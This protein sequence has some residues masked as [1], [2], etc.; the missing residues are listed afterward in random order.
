MGKLIEVK[1]LTDYSL[2][3]INCIEASAGTGKTYA[4][5]HLYLRLLIQKDYSIDN[6]L[7]VTFTNAATEELRKRI[8]LLIK[9]ARDMI[10]GQCNDEI[11][12]KYAELNQY[13]HTITQEGL[14]DGYK[15]EAS[16]LIEKLQFALREIDK[17]HIYT[18]HSFCRKTLNEFAFESRSL[19]GSTLVEDVRSYNQRIVEDFY[20]EKIVPLGEQFLTLFVQEKE[21]FVE[22]FLNLLSKIPDNPDIAFIP[23]IRINQKDILKTTQSLN[24]LIQH[25]KKL[26]T[27]QKEQIQNNYI[28]AIA[29]GVLNKRSFKEEDFTVLKELVSNLSLDTVMHSTIYKWLQKFSLTN[30][31]SKMNKKANPSYT[32]NEIFTYIDTCIIYIRSIKQQLLGLYREFV[33]YSEQRYASYRNEWNI[34]SFKDI[35]KDM[36]AALHGDSNSPL[37]QRVRGRFKAALIDEFQD[38]DPLQYS[39]FTTIFNFNKEEDTIYVIGDPK[40]AIYK[41]RGA[42]IFAYLNARNSAHTQYVL[43]KSYRSTN[44]LTN[45]CNTIFS[46]LKYPFIHD[47]I[48]YHQVKSDISDSGF[49]KDGAFHIWLFMNENGKPIRIPIVQKMIA[50]KIAQEILRLVNGGYTI[51]EEPIRFSDIA[52]LVRKNFEATLVQKILRKYNIKSVIHSNELVFQTQEAWE[53]LHILE[54]VINPAVTSVIK[55]ALITSILGYSALDIVKLEHSGGID[56]IKMKFAEYRQLWQRKGIVVMLTALFIDEAIVKNNSGATVTVNERICSFPDGERV[57]TNIMHCAEILSKVERTNKLDP[58]A[59]VE[60]LKKANSGYVTI[61]DQELRLE[62]D[63]NAVKIVTV[64][65]SKGLEYPIVFCPYLFDEMRLDDVFLV[66]KNVVNKMKDDNYRA[67]LCFKLSQDQQEVKN[68]IAEKADIPYE[69]LELEGKKEELAEMLR[70]A[71]VAMTRAKYRCYVAWGNINQRHTSALGYLFHFNEDT[72]ITHFIKNFKLDNYTIIHDINKLQKACESIKVEPVYGVDIVPGNIPAETPAQPQ[73]VKQLQHPLHQGWQITSY[74]SLTYRR[75]EEKSDEIHMPVLDR[76]TKA[77][78]SPFTFPAGAVPGLCIHKIF[79]TVPFDADRHILSDMVHSILLNYAIGAHWKDIVTAMVHNVLMVPLKEGFIPLSKVKADQRRHEL[80]FY[81]PVKDI[82]SKKLVSVFGQHNL[83]TGEYSQAMKQLAFSD[84]NG[85]M[86]GYID[87]VFQYDGLFYIIDW[88]SNLLGF[89]IDAYHRSKLSSAII[90]HYY[91]LQYTIYTVALHR[92][93]SHLF[94]KSYS[95]EKNFGGVFYIFVR[96]VDATKG[97]EYGIFYDKPDAVLIEKINDFF[98]PVRA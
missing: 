97:H 15:A 7:V 87:M 53:L 77:D 20:F 33:I 91:F 19:F 8:R 27:D 67:Y 31:V 50:K 21:N 12:N 48:D 75:E 57:I 43:T 92:Y 29:E 24:E 89:S 64:H 79:E 62:S 58:V 95:Y 81:F 70:V 73:L 14:P 60:W 68:Y 45:A 80:E 63:A 40:Q 69:E 26:F 51:N 59:V 11:Q 86:H 82:D 65:S 94:G 55:R 3:G 9:I 90:S 30:I 28:I 76:D 93:L 6:I 35:L 88:K 54:A 38:T 18:I 17:A 25:I 36:H 47:K 39:I 49:D 34:V 98:N 96:G 42:D 66:H 1:K 46:R 83:F 56:A 41:F 37:A 74:T 2:K 44:A 85:F 5:S 13:L 71:Y 61:E 52:I 22:W 4:I 78:L 32:F 10:A 16:E 84:I 23:D 72:K